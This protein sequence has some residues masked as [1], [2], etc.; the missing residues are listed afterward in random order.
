M[1]SVGRAA[2]LLGRCVSVVGAMISLAAIVIVLLIVVVWNRH[3][4]YSVDTLEI[5]GAMLGASSLALTLSVIAGFDEGSRFRIIWCRV[6]RSIGIGSVVLMSALWAG[7]AWW[8]IDGAHHVDKVAASEL[9]LSQIVEMG[10]SSGQRALYVSIDSR[11]V[12]AGLVSE[13]TNKH[14]KLSVRSIGELTAQQRTDGYA[15]PNSMIVNISGYSFPAWRVVQVSYT[16]NRCW[17]AVDYF[18]DSA[19]WRRMGQSSGAGC[20]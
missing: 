20:M 9:L 15:G 11:D 16:W 5:I 1:D 4:G 6:Q 7:H 8:V 2:R 14:P 18:Y 12:R 10:A 13:L 17:G 19:T 3:N